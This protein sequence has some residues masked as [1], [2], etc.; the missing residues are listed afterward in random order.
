MLD[1]MIRELKQPITQCWKWINQSRK[2]SKYIYNENIC[3]NAFQ[4]I[5]N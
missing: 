1:E 3:T 4:S 2:K 5:T